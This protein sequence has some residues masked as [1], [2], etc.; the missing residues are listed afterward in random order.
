R[1]NI[2]GRQ[3]LQLMEYVV[4]RKRPVGVQPK[5]YVLPEVLSPDVI[6]H[7]AFAL[8]IQTTDFD[9]DG[10]KSVGDLLANLFH[11]KVEVAHPDEPVDGDTHATNEIVVEN[12]ASATMR[13]I[14]P[15][16]LQSKAQRGIPGRHETIDRFKTVK[17]GRVDPRNQIR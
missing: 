13:Q 10:S 8:K 17:A 5:G 11:H 15:G 4:G 2:E 7:I 16:G 12:H 1:M 9:L 14:A 6:E 3:F